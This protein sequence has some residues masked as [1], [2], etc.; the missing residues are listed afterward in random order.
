MLLLKPGSH[1]TC[2]IV[3]ENAIKPISKWTSLARQRK[4]A[5]AAL[6][7]TLHLWLGWSFA[8]LK[9]VTQTRKQTDALGAPQ[10]VFSHRSNVVSL[11]DV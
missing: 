7:P 6:F 3:S 10:C 2:H 9:C 8:S 5:R 4:E 1:V 11:E